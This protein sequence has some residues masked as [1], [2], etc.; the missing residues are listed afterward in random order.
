MRGQLISCL[1]TPSGSQSSIER[2]DRVNRVQV[3][4]EL[5]CL[6]VCMYVFVSLLVNTVG[7]SDPFQFVK[8]HINLTFLG[9]I[10]DQAKK[11]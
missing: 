2:A 4:E 8:L 9:P 5:M 6:G 7:L 3:P 10:F 11:N 1:A